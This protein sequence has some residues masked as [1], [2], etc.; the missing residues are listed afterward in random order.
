MDFWTFSNE[1][2]SNAAQK[3]LQIF[4]NKIRNPVIYLQRNGETMK[5]KATWNYNYVAYEL[6]VWL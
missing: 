5:C 4:A 1:Y 2:N 6:R 3:I